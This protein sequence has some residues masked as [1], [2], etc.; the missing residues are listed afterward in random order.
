MGDLNCPILNF[1]S[2]LPM[3]FKFLTLI[4]FC[5]IFS[6][7]GNGLQAQPTPEG[8][9]VV[10]TL[11]EVRYVQRHHPFKDSI[12][13]DTIRAAM[14][15]VFQLDLPTTKTKRNRDPFDPFLHNTYIRVGLGRFWF[16]IVSVL[17]VGLFVYYRNAFPKQFN[18][19]LKGIT[20]PYY[21]KELLSDFGLSFTSGS[22]VAS[23]FSN[24]VLSQ[25][26]V[27]W[28]CTQDL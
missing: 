10:D 2:E 8:D 28:C 26:I 9:I 15:K 4:L 18:Q 7:I 24:L 25:L 19:R 13:N 6:I 17:V 14:H 1:I 16:F 12:L 20:N 23:I 3:R 5:A 27:L 11:G 22:I 21:F